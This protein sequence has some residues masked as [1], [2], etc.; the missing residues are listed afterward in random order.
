MELPRAC[1]KTA[2]RSGYNHPA[3]TVPSDGE[4]LLPP[5]LELSTCSI[6]T[7]RTDRH[8]LSASSCGSTPGFSWRSFTNVSYV[9]P[10]SPRPKIFVPRSLTIRKCL[11]AGAA[12]KNEKLIVASIV[13]ALEL[14]D[15]VGRMLSCRKVSLRQP[16]A[17]DLKIK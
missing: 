1:V 16:S 13:C 6:R 11:N 14:A 9:T 17:R 3:L 5:E 2:F 8:P 7:V 10:E 12:R 4:P 15:S